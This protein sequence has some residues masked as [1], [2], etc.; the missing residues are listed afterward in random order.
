MKN[1]SSLAAHFAKRNTKNCGGEK[2]GRA[3]IPSPNP[4]PFCPPSLSPP[5]NFVPTKLARRSKFQF[6]FG[7]LSNFSTNTETIINKPTSKS[8]TLQILRFRWITINGL[9]STARNPK[10]QIH[11]SFFASYDIQAI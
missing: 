5:P 10:I 6:V 4:L 3:K 8:I 9:K 1:N 11:F 2:R 7:L